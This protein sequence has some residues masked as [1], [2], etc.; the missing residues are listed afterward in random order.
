MFVAAAALRHPGW[1]HPGDREVPH[2]VFDWSPDATVDAL[3]DCVA[4]LSAEI[5]GAV[6]G[7]IP[8]R[9]KYDTVSG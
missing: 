8:C 6:D 1:K 4:R 2:L 9:D 7:A 3:Q 5:S